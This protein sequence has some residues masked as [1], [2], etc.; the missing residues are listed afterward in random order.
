[1]VEVNQMSDMMLVTIESQLKYRAGEM[2]RAL[3]DPNV[4][5]IASGNIT[6]FGEDL[7]NFF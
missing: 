1:M 6:E 7:T 2:L 3:S 5:V 4:Y